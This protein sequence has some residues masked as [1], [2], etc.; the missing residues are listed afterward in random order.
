MNIGSTK[1]VELGKAVQKT[2][3]GC[4]YLP[5]F[6]TRCTECKLFDVCKIYHSPQQKMPEARIAKWNKP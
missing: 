2:I 1:Q 3:E 4:N 5:E 6:P